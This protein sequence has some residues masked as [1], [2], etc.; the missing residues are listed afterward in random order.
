LVNTQIKPAP[1]TA[2]F[3]TATLEPPAAVVFV[4][5][6]VPDPVRVP[7]GSVIVNGLGEIETVPRV[8]TPAPVSETGVGVTV[9][10]V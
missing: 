6:T 5:V 8:A 4:R 10:P 2:T 7:A 9:A 3:V 1:E